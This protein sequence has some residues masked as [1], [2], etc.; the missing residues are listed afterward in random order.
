MKQYDLILR[1]LQYGMTITSNEAQNMYG[2]TRLSARIHEMKKCGFDIRKTI[3]TGVNRFGER[4]RYA[5]YWLKE[6]KDAVS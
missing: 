6:K 4:T 1:H 2:C 3:E 5:R